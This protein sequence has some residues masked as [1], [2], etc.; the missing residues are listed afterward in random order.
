MFPKFLPISVPF[1]ATLNKIFPKIVM[2]WVTPPGCVLDNWVFQN[3]ILAD[4]PFTK[5]L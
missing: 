3:F 4:Q 1:L 2:S 5:A